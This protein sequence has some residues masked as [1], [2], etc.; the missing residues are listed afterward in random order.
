MILALAP[1]RVSP[2]NPGG[3]EGETIVFL[4]GKVKVNK[5]EKR[6]EAFMQFLQTHVLP[7][8]LALWQVTDTQS[9]TVIHNN[10]KIKLKQRRKKGRYGISKHQKIKN[11]NK[12]KIL[13]YFFY[14]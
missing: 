4:L 7:G 5:S 13:A 6:I 1:R 2:G 12:N 8:K 14:A 11:K 9:R 3:R 10:R